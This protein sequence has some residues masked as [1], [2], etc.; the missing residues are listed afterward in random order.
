MARRGLTIT[1]LEL[2]MTIKTLA[3]KGQSRRAIA[4]QLDLCEGTVRYH[5]KRM[6]SGAI[7]G[8][9][10][11]ARVAGDYRK[12]IDHWMSGREAMSNLAALH[13]WLVAEHDYT[14]SLRSVQRFVRETYP[15]PLRRAR[16]RI[17][18]PPGAQ[19]QADWASYPRMIVA[20]EAVTLHAF[21]LVLSHSRGEA[22]VWAQDQSQLSWLSSHNA[23]FTRLG[24]IPAV[25]RV[26]NTKT[27]VAH[28]AGRWG[29]LN[30]TYRRYATT[31]R[32][33]VDP[34][35]PYSPE[36][37][38]K[39]ERAVRTCRD[40]FDATAGAWDSVAELQTQTDLAVERS[41]RRRRCP[42]TG[43]SIWQA[44]QDERRSLAPLPILPQPFDHVATR[45]VGSDALVHF[46]GHQ[47]SVPFAHLGRHVEIRGG[48]GVVQI[49]ADH[50]IIAEHPRHTDRRLVIDP[51]HYEGSS[52]A[53]VQA[54][55]PLGRLGQRLQEL[56][57]VPV[58]RRPIDL[59]AA[60]AEVAR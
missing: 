4:R 20:G 22:V 28:G 41:A 58:E 49:L 7:D 59:Y 43:S 35:A 36:H 37:K 3:A 27:A 48:A 55:T 26:D 52:T 33:H 9:A 18:T 5:L 54:P 34:C 32:F 53:R 42:A 8:R 46:E 12:A 38:G 50:S 56:A 44:W 16:R 31:V 2:R 51:T 29:Q 19:A 60:L 14:G 15:P 10:R 17:E 40:G 13:D 30:E 45:P 39:V 6:A 24:G 21:H 57:A 47:Y 11:Q 23:A 25:V 1:D